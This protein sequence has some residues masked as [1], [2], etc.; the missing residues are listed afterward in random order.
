MIYPFEIDNNSL[1]FAEK[2]YPDLPTLKKINLVSQKER[3]DI[4]RLY[5]TEGIPYA[6]I[7]NPV[8]YEKIRVWL[9]RHLEVNPKSI[10]IT[11]SARIGYTINPNKIQGTPF[12]ANSDLDFIIVDETFFNNMVIDYFKFV[13][14]LNSKLS[15]NQMKYEYLLNQV[16]EIERSITRY[17]FI[18][19]WKIPNWSGLSKLNLT[20][21][22]LIHLI[23]R[24]NI[25][26]NCPQVSKASIRIF[27]DWESCVN[28]LTYNIHDALK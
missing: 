10:S 24:M 3:V 18:D 5:F 27:K 16:L 21:N 15:Q 1:D 4:V 28:R 2:H 20:N 19:Q 17:G 7:K 6:F 11:G 12:T 8:L 23:E 13:E 22:N 9:A 14:Q 25:T 26:N